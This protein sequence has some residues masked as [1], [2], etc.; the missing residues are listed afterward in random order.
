MTKATRL[1]R[2]L[3]A[4]WA[5]SVV[6]VGGALTSFHQPFAVPG[7]GVMALAGHP[8]GHGWRAIHFLSGSCPCSQRVMLHLLARPR[9]GDVAEE[10]VMIDGSLPYLADSPTLLARLAAGHF[11]IRHM[12]EQDVPLD[13]GLR[14]VPLLLFVSP[15]NQIAYMGGYGAAGDQDETIFHQLRAGRKPTALPMIGCAVGSRLQRR[16]DPLHLKY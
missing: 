2:C 9:W 5:G 15:Q 8:S 6:L 7:N 10:I 3:L 13:S 16:L 1:A 11:L 14:G 4:V 12:A